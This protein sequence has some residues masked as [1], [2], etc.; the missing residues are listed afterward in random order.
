M[1]LPAPRSTQRVVLMPGRRVDIST[2]P[3]PMDRAAAFE[4]PLECTDAGES[5]TRVRRRLE[6]R[7]AKPL[8]PLLDPLFNRW[9][10]KDIP[11]ELARLKAHLE[12]NQAR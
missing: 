5:G 10:T 12:R 3:S 6:F 11:A 9:L 2:V 1:G 7:F 4:A 8:S